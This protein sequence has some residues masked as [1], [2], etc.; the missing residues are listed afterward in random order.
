MT[1]EGGMGLALRA[2]GIRKEYGKHVVVD[3]DHVEVAAGETLALL[4]PSGAGKTTL[5][6]VLGLLEKPDA[7]QV[8]LDGRP[9]S[10][11]DTQARMQMAA[12]FQSPYLFKGT[13]ADNVAYGLK[14]RGIPAARRREA[15]A[16]ALERVGL[17]GWESRSALTLSGGEAQ[18]VALARALVL[19]P[20]VLLLDEPLSSLDPLIK[21]RLTQDFARIIHEDSMT[22]V[23][24]T[25]DQNE[26]MAVAE[27][28]VIL[29]DG[30]VVA[31]GHVDDVMGLPPD[32]WTAGFLGSEPPLAGTVISS[33][34]GLVAIDVGGPVVYA[35]G[36][37]A[38]GTRVMAGVRPEDVLLFEGTAD[39]PRS[40]ARNRFQGTVSDIQL[41]GV[42][43]HMVV[44][45]DG[46]RI[47]SRVSRASV[48]EMG[49]AQGSQV[50]VVFKATAVRVR[51][52]DESGRLDRDE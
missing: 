5:L 11:K 9:V 41:W 40:T 25:H 49:L 21:G 6:A 35:T 7:G 18:R 33:A 14:L 34:E 12:A 1:T 29:R 23:Y 50:Q 30:R 45:V 10:S 8:F 37:I 32:D 19:K 27:T 39:I 38:P 26:A 17:S 22:T 3:I 36:E 51:P 4:G 20:R 2:E 28:V 13:I 48:R 24:V 47:A 43:Y 15:V 16:E 52:F 46:V 44:E 42:M 31:Q